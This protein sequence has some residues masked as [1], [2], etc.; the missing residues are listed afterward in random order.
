MHIKQGMPENASG[1]LKKRDA[2][3]TNT[4]KRQKKKGK[5]TQ[6]GFF[7]PQKICS[8]AYNRRFSASETT[9]KWLKIIRE[10]GEISGS[11]KPKFC[12][13]VKKRG[14]NT[15]FLKDKNANKR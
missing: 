1:P 3:K 5:K 4:N 11:K 14:K 9:P 15:N 10:L 7:S 12:F 2:N 8:F 6:I 13:C